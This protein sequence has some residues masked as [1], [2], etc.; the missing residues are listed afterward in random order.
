MIVIG[1]LMDQN[2][3]QLRYVYEAVTAVWSIDL[4]PA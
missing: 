4:S 2:G 1:A 3:I